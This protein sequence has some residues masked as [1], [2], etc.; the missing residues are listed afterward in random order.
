MSE[1]PWA[2]HSDDAGAPCDCVVGHALEDLRLVGEPPQDRGLL[3]DLAQQ[4]GADGGQPRFGKR[5]HASVHLACDEHGNAAAAILAR[6]LADEPVPVAAVERLDEFD[7]RVGVRVAGALEEKGGGVKRYVE[8]S[9]LLLV[10]DRRLDRL[11]AVGDRDAVALLEQLV[12]R[13]LVE[14]LRRQARDQRLADVQR[15]D[16]HRRLVGEPQALRDHD[17]L[18]GR[19]LQTAAEPRAGGG[20]RQRQRPRTGAHPTPPH[21]LAERGHR[22][23][24]GDLR[25]AHER[26]A[27]APPH[28]VALAHEVVERGTH[29]QARNAQI[30]AQLAL[31]GDRRANP[32]LFDQVAYAVAGLTLLGGHA[33]AILASLAQVV[34]TTPLSSG[35]KRSRLPPR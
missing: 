23:L 29:G 25:L 19:D 20:H 35:S 7:D 4:Q 32:E 12:E 33:T 27:A 17:P 30:D 28:Q 2:D 21:L 8:L 31:G 11:D 22:Q 15:L 1:E 26:A 5:A 6:Q 24:L 16:R 18:G 9:R 3:A 14:I 34:N 13:G 10:R